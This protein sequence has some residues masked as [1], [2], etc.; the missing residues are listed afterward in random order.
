MKPITPREQQTMQL[1]AAG[2]SGKDVARILRISL[3]TVE[4]HKQGI[5]YKWRVNSNTAMIRV[6][7]RSGALQLE[8][9]LASE[10]GE[11]QLHYVPQHL[12]HTVYHHTGRN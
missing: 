6:A 5:Y 1:L 12:G 9:F 11:H 4:K 7:L 2:Y 10:V 8:D 3:K